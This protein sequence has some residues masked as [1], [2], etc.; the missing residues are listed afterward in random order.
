MGSF[1]LEIPRTYSPLFAFSTPSQDVA[2]L[3]RY[4]IVDEKLSWGNS[5]PCLSITFSC[6]GNSLKT[7]LARIRRNSLNGESTTACV[8]LYCPMT[9]ASSFSPEFYELLCHTTSTFCRKRGNMF[10]SLCNLQATGQLLTNETYYNE[11][12]PSTKE[13]IFAWEEGNSIPTT[14][15]FLSSAFHILCQ[16]FNGSIQLRASKWM[17]F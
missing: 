15:I 17:H 8:H 11:I 10:I 4:R 7:F 14:G 6:H 2:P 5:S 12:I 16:D 1:I 3:L 13:L 9:W